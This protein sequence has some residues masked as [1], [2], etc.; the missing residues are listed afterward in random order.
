MYTYTYIYI[1]SV[2]LFFIFTYIYIYIYMRLEG[3]AL[4]NR[5]AA[6]RTRRIYPAAAA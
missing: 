2:F 6:S 5:L 4:A 3:T 1:Y